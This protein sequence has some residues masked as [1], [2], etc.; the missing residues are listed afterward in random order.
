[1]DGVDIQVG[2]AELIGRCD[3]HSSALV[4]VLEAARA[5]GW[6]VA[7]FSGAALDVVLG[8]LPRDLDFVVQGAGWEDGVSELFGR[9]ERTAFGGM[10]GRV[11]GVDVDV[12]GLEQTRGFADLGLAPSFK[13]LAATAFFNVNA[14]CVEFGQDGQVFGA[15][16]DAGFFEAMRTRTLEVVN[17]HSDFAPY[18]AAKTARLVSRGFAVGD[19]LAEWLASRRIPSAKVERVHRMIYGRDAGA[20]R[21]VAALSGFLAP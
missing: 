16:H 7:L 3:Q 12:W 18:Q 10:R 8:D 2:I 6:R 14:V 4:S 15:V 9:V 11:H 1:M 19:S 13:S 5:G 17:P 20:D 21:E